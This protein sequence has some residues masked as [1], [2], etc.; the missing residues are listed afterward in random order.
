MGPSSPS[1]G[2]ISPGG[3]YINPSIK[4]LKK[5]LPDLPPTLSWTGGSPPTLPTVGSP[6]CPPGLSHLPVG[7]CFLSLCLTSRGWALFGQHKS[8]SGFWKKLLPRKEFWGLL[9]SLKVSL[10]YLIFDNYA[11]YR[12]LKWKWIPSVS[13]A[14]LLGLLWRSGWFLCSFSLGVCRISLCLCF[15][16]SWDGC[17]LSAPFKLE[18]HDI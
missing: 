14:L 7:P 8:S 15:E 3:P 13:E 12:N 18:V 2:W 4:F 1:V 5:S 16:V 11:G 6:R 17:L 10:F 9:E